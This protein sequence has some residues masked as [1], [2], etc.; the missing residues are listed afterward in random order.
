M[1]LS[2]GMMDGPENWVYDLSEILKIHLSWAFSVVMILFDCWSSTM[3]LLCY[4]KL[5][6]LLVKVSNC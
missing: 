2:S 1:G 3:N 4:T 6:L 5:S